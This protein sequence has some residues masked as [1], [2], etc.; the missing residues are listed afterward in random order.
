MET[1]F[2]TIQKLYPIS[3]RS[4]KKLK[5]ILFKKEFKK[6]DVLASLHSES[7]K[8]YLV[9]SG[10]ARSFVT[11]EKGKEHTR[12]LYGPT[13]AVGALSSLIQ[14]QKSDVIVDCITD[15]ILFEVDFNEFKKLT[16][17][18]IDLLYLYNS[19]LEILF[20]KMENRFYELSVLDATQLYLKF[21]KD[22][23]GME[24]SIPL[25]HIASYLNITSVQLSRIR[26]QLY[27]S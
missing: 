12:S 11:D 4:A 10:I 21:K 23:P 26:K 25:Y 18:N 3:D 27:K 6:R 8:F 1:L 16:K 24:N 22:N 20:V 2:N 5:K 7:S 17:K 15:C 14:K 9:K 19:L 13:T